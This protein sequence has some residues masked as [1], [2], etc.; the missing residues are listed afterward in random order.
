MQTSVKKGGTGFSAKL[1]VN[2]GV[3]E[4]GWRRE[5]GISSDIAFS[6]HQ[7]HLLDCTYHVYTLE[8]RYCRLKPQKAP[9]GPT[10]S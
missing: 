3:V 7:L 8:V 1:V 5:C 4:S 6:G 10:T 9:V 2:R